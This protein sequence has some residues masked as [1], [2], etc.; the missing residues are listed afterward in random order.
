MRGEKG[1]QRARTSVV[2]ACVGSVIGSALA[3]LTILAGDRIGAGPV[4]LLAGGLLV[5]AAAGRPDQPRPAVEKVL[6]GLTDRVFDG[7]ILAAIIWTARSSDPGL[8]AA[9]LACFAFG[10]LAAYARARA[11]GLGYNVAFLSP[12]SVVKV[13]GV[14]LTLL[15]GWGS[16]GL[17][18][19]TTWLIIATTVRVSQVWKES[20]A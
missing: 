14:G 1:L 15:L 12:I 3:A 13:G 10:S 5:I 20:L 7:T 2:L 18:A 6:I 8:A 16:A 17:I 4:A 11:L 9:A 19:V